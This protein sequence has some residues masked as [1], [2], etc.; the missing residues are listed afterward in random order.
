MT[1]S[2]FADQVALTS[3]KN[4]LLTPFFALLF[5]FLA[6]LRQKD[7]QRDGFTF[8]QTTGSLSS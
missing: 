8:S 6:C 4:L 1:R 2:E 5:D 7:L 3:L